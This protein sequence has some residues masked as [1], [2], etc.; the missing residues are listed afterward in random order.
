MTLAT[1]AATLRTH[2]LGPGWNPL[3]RIAW[4]RK[5]RRLLGVA[6]HAVIWIRGAT[7]PWA[8]WGERHGY[9]RIERMDG[10]PYLRPMAAV[11]APR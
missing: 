10:L 11:A 7:G 4:C 9:F 8:D 1:L 2:L 6:G 5:Q 3:A